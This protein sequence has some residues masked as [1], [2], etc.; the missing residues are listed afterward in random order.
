MN[1]LRKPEVVCGIALGAAVTALYTRGY[2]THRTRHNVTA[3]H[4][5]RQDNDDETTVSGNSLARCGRDVVVHISTFLECHEVYLLMQVSSSVHAACSGELLWMVL[6]EAAFPPK[7]EAEEQQAPSLLPAATLTASITVNGQTTTYNPTQS[8][9]PPPEEEIVFPA[10]M[11]WKERF[12]TALQKQRAEL[13]EFIRLEGEAQERPLFASLA[14]FSPWSGPSRGSVFGSLITALEVR[15]YPDRYRDWSQRCSI[16][17]KALTRVASC[18][19][20]ACSTSETWT[21]EVFLLK[22]CEFY[23]RSKLTIAFG[24]AMVHVSATL[25]FQLLAM[26]KG[27]AGLFQFQ[28]AVVGFGGRLLEA[29]LQYKRIVLL[30]AVA[31]VAGASDSHVVTNTGMHRTL[32]SRNTLLYLVHTLVVQ[33]VSF[34]FVRDRD[35][36]VY[37]QGEVWMKKVFHFTALYGTVGAVVA[38][39]LRRKR[40]ALVSIFIPLNVGLRYLGY[41]AH[42]PLSRMTA[43]I[44]T[45]FAVGKDLDGLSKA[46]EGAA[47]LLLLPLHNNWIQRALLFLVQNV[48]SP[49][50]S[51]SFS[52][53]YLNA[54]L[55]FFIGTSS[56]CVS[57]KH[58]QGVG[59]TFHLLLHMLLS[60]SSLLRPP[61][62][63]GEKSKK[64]KS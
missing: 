39:L 62:K 50:Q 19:K 21:H 1:S 57:I 43:R 14:Q 22:A 36:T 25:L 56:S 61:P 3:P 48:L 23:N 6:Y 15:K 28:D 18:K 32:L 7:G 46:T 11:P 4:P 52:W 44:G 9:P 26:W 17:H 13:L 30:T 63:E 24:Y 47:T 35:A 5:T 27:G 51:L 29:F 8:V 55:H 33:S 54:W 53:L 2:T 10:S 12:Y 42:W 34:S 60:V 64:K 16:L 38:T 37:R 58:G 31:G 59:F 49:H 20:R 45:M 41:R 40:P